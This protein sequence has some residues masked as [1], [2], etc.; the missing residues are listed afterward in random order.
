MREVDEGER[1]V[2][3]QESHNVARSMQTCMKEGHESACTHTESHAPFAGLTA[4]LR[5]TIT[6]FGWESLKKSQ[7]SIKQLIEFWY[8]YD[9]I[10]SYK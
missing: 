8:I 10:Q 7:H 3:A 5:K 1:H 4:G 9:F 6:A 2:R